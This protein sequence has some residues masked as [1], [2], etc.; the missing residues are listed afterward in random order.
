MHRTSFFKFFSD[1]MPVANIV[2]YRKRCRYDVN[3]N[4]CYES[5]WHDNSIIGATRFDEPDDPMAGCDYLGIRQTTIGLAIRYA[6][7]EWPLEPVTLY[8]YDAHVNN[9]ADYDALQEDETGHIV[10]VRESES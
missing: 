7:Q 3:V 1:N 10:P 4:V 2:D 9:Y 8:L 6:A 5:S